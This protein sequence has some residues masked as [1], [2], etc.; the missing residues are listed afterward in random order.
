MSI[1][2]KSSMP[3]P[4][5]QEMVAGLSDPN[6]FEVETILDKRFIMGYVEYQIKWKG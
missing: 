6:I 2:K 3:V 4:N 1:S 5:E